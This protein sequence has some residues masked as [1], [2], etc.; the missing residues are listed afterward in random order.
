MTRSI[1]R[2][3]RRVARADGRGWTPASDPCGD[4]PLRLGAVRDLD[5][6]IVVRIAMPTPYECG[7]ECCG[8]ADYGLRVVPQY[9]L[10]GCNMTAAEY[11]RWESA[12]GIA[13]LCQSALA[14]AAELVAAKPYDESGNLAS[15]RQQLLDAG[16]AEDVAEHCAGQILHFA[17]IK[18]DAVRWGIM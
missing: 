3:I 16:H 10:D 18:A 9:L 13:M 7:V 14:R 8:M 4:V 1:L 2:S 17:Q 5:G 12:C 11:D 15:V 6:V